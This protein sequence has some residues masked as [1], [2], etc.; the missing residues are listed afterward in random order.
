MRQPASGPQWS[1]DLVTTLGRE[2]AIAID[3]DATG[4]AT[5][6]DHVD[7]LLAAAEGSLAAPPDLARLS[8]GDLSGIATA[9]SADLDCVVTAAALR[10]ALERTMWY[11]RADDAEPGRAPDTAT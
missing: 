9:M 8:A 3:P 4:P 1:P 2:L 6:G 5:P 7:A 11:W 10:Q